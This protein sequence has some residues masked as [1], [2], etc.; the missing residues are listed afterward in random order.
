[1]GHRTP[2]RLQGRLRGNLLEFKNRGTAEDRVKDVEIRILRSRCDQC[3]L[4]VFNILQQGLLLLFIKGLD[5]IQVQQNAVGGHKGIQLGYDVLDIRCGGRGG[6]QLVECPVGL[7]G[8]DLGDGGLAG[9]A[10]AVEDH[11]GNIAGL[12][13]TAQNRVLSKICSC[14]KTSSKL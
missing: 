1:M 11:V 4:A 5:L 10:G 2:D 12:D 14:P 9:A 8:Y 7:L 6:V 13:Q 3:D